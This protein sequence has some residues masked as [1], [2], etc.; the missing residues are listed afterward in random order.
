MQHVH[1]AAPYFGKL[2]SEDFEIKRNRHMLQG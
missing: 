2:S 1:M